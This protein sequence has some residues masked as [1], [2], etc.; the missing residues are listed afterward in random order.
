V[1]AKSTASWLA[2]A[3]VFREVAEPPP[4][5][6]HTMH[7]TGTYL[8]TCTSGITAFLARI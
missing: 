1:S 4:A 8:T 3:L 7:N 6:A 2:I 5:A